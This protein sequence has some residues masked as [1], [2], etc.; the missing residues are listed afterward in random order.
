MENIYKAIFALSFCL[1]HNSYGETTMSEPVAK[2]IPHKMT[3][4]NDTRTDNYFWLKDKTNPAVIEH[5]KAEN[6]YAEK[7]MKGT[8]ALQENLYKEMRGRIKEADKSYPYREKNYYYFTQT[9][10]GK[11]YPVYKRMRDLNSPEET[12]IDVNE[13]AIGKAFIRVG[14]PQVAPDEKTIAYAVDTKGDRIHTIFFKDLTL[15]K[16]FDVRIENVT[17]NMD[18]AEN[19][20]ILY[21]TQQDPKTLRSH[22][23]FRFNLDSRQTELLYEEKDE[24]FDVYVYKTLSRKFIIIHSASTL[25]TEI[26]YAPA[27]ES[28]PPFTIFLNREKNHEYSI[29][30]GGD[31]FF[32]RTN[33]AAKNFRIMQT[34]YSQTDKKSWKEVVPHRLDV[35]IEDYRTFKTF[36]ALNERS[37]GLTRLSVLTRENYKREDLQFPD[38][39]YMVSIGNNAEFDTTKLRYDYESMT[40][41][42]SVY[43]YNITQKTTELLKEKTVPTYQS[44]DYASERLFV[45]AKDGAMIPVSLLYKKGFVKNAKAPILI[46]GYGSY[47]MSMD[48]YFSIGNVSLVDR[49]FVFAVA[50]VRGGSEMGR[51]WYDDGKFLKKKNTFNDFIAVT[52]FLLKEKYADPKHVYAMGGSA[53]GLLMGA[54]MNQRPD[55]YHGIVA[56]VPFVDVMTTMLDSSLPLT[57]GEYEEWGN[58]NELKYYRYMKS[59]SPYDNVKAQAYPHLLVT[60]GLNDSQVG[61]W[62]PAKWVAKL[63]DMRTDKTKLLLMKTEMEVG[64]G[65]KSGRFEYLRERAFEY[66]FIIHLSTLHK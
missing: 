44:A 63:R 15:N 9:L 37:R 57:T 3:I 38:P 65:G 36:L 14:H 41:P 10:E 23:V 35:F 43:E 33:W 5:L 17:G 20:R 49:G 54:V 50:H 22:K 26:R 21:Y 61:Y 18:W 4:H 28:A 7:M 48:P 6:T 12:M 60:T 30:D 32:I 11:E 66:A 59:Y 64:H 40:R 1:L 45:P 52:E 62:E 24:K 19:G 31:R 56:Q 8:K 58:P 34:T 55:L 16:V 47:G 25:S 27:T 53:G 51:K 2:K 39:V 42:E 13:M 46:Y 29:D